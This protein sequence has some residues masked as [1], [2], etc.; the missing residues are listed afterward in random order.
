L[1]IDKTRERESKKCKENESSL[2]NQW[3]KEEMQK[4]RPEQSEKKKAPRE[5]E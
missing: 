3:R 1:Y 2:F 5:E 4:T